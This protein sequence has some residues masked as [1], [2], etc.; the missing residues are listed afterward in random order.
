MSDLIFVANSADGTISSFD[1]DDDALR[2]LGVTEVAPGLTL[3]IDP[4]RE[5]MY[6]GTEDAIITLS[7][8]DDTLTPIAETSAK[9]SSTSLC[10][11][12]DGT[13]LLSASYGDGLGEVWRVDGEKLSPVGDP[14]EFDNLHCV[15]ASKEGRHAYFVSLG[16]DLIAQFAL[17]DDG[18][19]TALAQPIVQLE[20]GVGARHLVLDDAERRAYLITEYT[21]MVYSFDRADDGTLTPTGMVAGHPVGRGLEESRMGADPLAEGLIW[22]ADVRISPN[23]KLLFTSERTK[24]TLTALPINDDGTLQG[25]TAHSGVVAQP[26]FFWMLSDDRI[27]V[28]GERSNTIGLYAV[29]AQGAVTLRQ[30]LE[31]GSEPNWVAVLAR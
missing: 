6:A 14:I 21:G 28:C 29:D 22:G 9:G 19:L 7:I 30:E 26:R 4:A 20:T 24:S 5:L 11:T 15:I 27:L 16:Q 23:G 1:Y 31:V 12:Q 2:P 3:A 10:L 18:T 13:R 25:A 8:D 17:A